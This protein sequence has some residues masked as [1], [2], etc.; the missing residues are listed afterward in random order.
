M[1]VFCV[2]FFVV[3]V[4]G[5]GFLGEG[6]VLFYKLLL[7]QGFFFSV[8]MT[9][10]SER[11]QAYH[12]FSNTSSFASYKREC[13]S[14]IGCTHML[15][16]ETCSHWVWQRELNRAVMLRLWVHVNL[17]SKY[18]WMKKSGGFC[19]VFFNQ[20]VLVLW[21]IFIHYTNILFT[22][23]VSIRVQLTALKMMAV[24]PHAKSWGGKKNSDVDTTL[25]LARLH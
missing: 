18:P 6:V 12:T 4:F 9:I 11:I 14:M 17:Y 15:N 1:G 7:H 8:Q 5:W 20:L 2:F 25:S 16:C 24:F 21:E 13:T 23:I 19:W 10:H 3:V 22:I